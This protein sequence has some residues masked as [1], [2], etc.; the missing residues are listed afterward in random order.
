MSFVGRFPCR[1]EKLNAKVLSDIQFH[2]AAGKR[3]LRTPSRRDLDT[4]GVKEDE[5]K[6]FYTALARAAKQQR[7]KIAV[8]FCEG[9]DPNATHSNP[10][11]GPGNCAASLA[12]KVWLVHCYQRWLIGRGCLL[13]P[14][15][16]SVDASLG[17]YRQS[18]GHIYR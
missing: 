4:N 18:Q 6:P 10:S 3:D 9:V 8:I 14:G 1:T 15:L 17:M 12:E 11:T 16:V 7:D 2:D 13:H 5:A